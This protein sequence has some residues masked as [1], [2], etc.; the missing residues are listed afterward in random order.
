MVPPTRRQVLAGIL[1][2]VIALAA[3]GIAMRSHGR[4]NGSAPVDGAVAQFAPP[5]GGTST[6]SAAELVVDVAGEVHRPGVYHLPAGSRVLDAIASAGGATGDAQLGAVNRAA[7]VVDGQQVLVPARG[8]PGAGGVVVG[9]GGAPSG[10]VSLS[11]ATAEQLDALPG[12][13]PATAQRILD[14]REEHGAFRTVDELDAVPGIGPSHLDQL[15]G[16]VAP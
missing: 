12:V 16:L 7:P 1:A 13:G 2:A 9:G 8:S 6:T 10:P 4:G 3:I 5:G 11:S 15:R 14:Y